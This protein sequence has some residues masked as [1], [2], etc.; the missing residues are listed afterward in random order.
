MAKDTLCV[1]LGNVLIEFEGKRLGKFIKK[2]KYDLFINNY[3][4]K[5]DTDQLDLWSLYQELKFQKFFKKEILWEVFVATYGECIIG[6]NWEMFDAL[7]SLK[8]AGVNLV[9][10]TD[11]N[12]FMFTET[13]IRC[14]EIFRLF[15]NKDGED[16]FILSYVL[17]S[18]KR[19]LNPFIHAPSI[20]GFSN[21]DACFVDDHE[22]NLDA[23]VKCGYVK[24]ACF[25][26]NIKSDHNHY[27]FLEF[28]EKH[29]LAK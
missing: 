17:G 9:C 10:I 6:I 18:L 7:L 11:N 25:L 5:H 19:K 21:K 23:A 20:F 14:P 15:R 16:Q 12:H 28:I 24:D 8:K 2:E 29:F 27:E 22:Y 26:Y 4:V 13:T 1:D 3:V